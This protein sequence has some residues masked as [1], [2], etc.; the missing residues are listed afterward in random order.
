MKRSIAIGALATNRHRRDPKRQGIGTRRDQSTSPKPIRNRTD[1]TR[2]RPLDMSTSGDN[3]E[4]VPEVRYELDS[5]KG[6]E[7]H[8]EPPGSTW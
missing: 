7:D 1:W 6:N 3:T 5:Y 8:E 4:A 2:L